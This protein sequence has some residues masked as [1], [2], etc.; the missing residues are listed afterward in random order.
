[1]KTQHDRC[2]GGQTL[3]QFGQMKINAEFKP[4]S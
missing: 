2:H 1:M 4:D 3:S